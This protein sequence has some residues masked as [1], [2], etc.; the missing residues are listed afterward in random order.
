M[1]RRWRK[2]MGVVLQKVTAIPL[3]RARLLPSRRTRPG[4]ARLPP[5]RAIPSWEGEATAEPCDPIPG[6]ETSRRY[7]R[8][9]GLT[10]VRLSRSFALPT[11][12]PPDHTPNPAV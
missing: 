12:K 9:S 3:G 4:R 1:A 5:S 10:G 2:P 11:G 7:A 8:S 6:G